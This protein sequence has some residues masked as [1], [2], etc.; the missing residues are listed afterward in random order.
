MR[1]KVCP[2]KPSR[3]GGFRPFDRGGLGAWQTSVENGEHYHTDLNG[4]QM[5]WEREW[6]R[7]VPV[8]P[9]PAGFV[10]FNLP[11]S[12]ARGPGRQAPQVLQ[13]DSD[14]RQLLSHVLPRI[15]A[16]PQEVCVKWRGMGKEVALSVSKGGGLRVFT[17][18]LVAQAP[19][20]E[21]AVG[22]GGGQLAPGAAALAISRVCACACYCCWSQGHVLLA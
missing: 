7:E 16:G 18:G 6:P 5:R 2:G 13:A 4:F 17:L 1:F 19:F 14:Q 9:C 12:L 21:H 22:R 15:L 10:S 20:S 11:F 8:H 3:E